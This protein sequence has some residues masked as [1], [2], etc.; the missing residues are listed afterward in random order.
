MIKPIVTVGDIHGC[1]EEFDEL[2]KTIQYKKEQLDLILLGDLVHRGPDS[3]G[4]VRRSRELGIPSVKGNHDDKQVRFRKHELKR[5]Q[6]GKS[7]PM[8]AT[9]G[10]AQLDKQLSDEDIA[11]MDALPLKLDLGLG[12][13]AIHG[14]LES[15]LSLDN[16]SSN[17]LLRTRFLNKEGKSVPLNADKSQPQDTIFWSSVWPGP[18]SIVYGHMVNPFFKPRWDHH[19]N[20]KCIGIDTGCCF[21]GSL[22]ALILTDVN[23]HTYS[24]N[25]VSVNAKSVYCKK[26]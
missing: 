7:N 20:H 8:K 3:V 15:S 4:C 26:Y 25:I 5:A 16:Q 23:Q 24:T 19:F 12:W 17:S 22:S 11:W 1:L 10:V 13:W 6:T 2:L 18:Q 14:G 21:G 9:D